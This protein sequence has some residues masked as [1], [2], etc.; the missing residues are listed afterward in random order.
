M[1]IL[2][3]DTTKKRGIFNTKWIERS[4]TK[5]IGHNLNPQQ[6]FMVLALEVWFREIVDSKAKQST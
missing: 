3:D 4:F 2:L 6:L 1:G 5:K